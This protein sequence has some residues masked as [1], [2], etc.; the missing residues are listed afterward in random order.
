MSRWIALLLIVFCQSDEGNVPMSRCICSDGWVIYL[1]VNGT[2]QAIAC[3]YS[4]IDTMDNWSRQ[5][6]LYYDINT[7]HTLTRWKQ[8]S[9]PVV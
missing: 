5:V 2:A 6:A 7:I 1:F 3:E 9:R 4:N 8:F